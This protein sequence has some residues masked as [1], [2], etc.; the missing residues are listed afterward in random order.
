ML[1]YAAAQPW[2]ELYRSSLP[3]AGED[4]TLSDRMKNT[5][6]GRP[7]LRENRNDRARE[8]AFRL[9]DDR[10]VART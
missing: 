3:V 2:G 5:P 9:R 1:R 7:C 8:F 10:H 4:G 6:G